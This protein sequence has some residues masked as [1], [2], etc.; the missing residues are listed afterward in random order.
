MEIID[1]LNQTNAARQQILKIVELF[2]GAPADYPNPDDPPRP[3][4]PW[5]PIIR[6]A[7]GETFV[8]KP[9]PQPWTDPFSLY[10]RSW[11]KYVQP[12]P[13]P[14]SE[15]FEDADLLETIAR[16]HPQ[17][18]DLIGDHRSFIEA[19]L[20][21]QPLPPRWRLPEAV[22]KSL[23]RRADAARDALAGLRRGGDLAERGIIIVG[24]REFRHLIE[25]LCGNDF[26]FWRPKPR[27]RGWKNSFDALDY[28]AMAAQFARAA[29]ESAYDDLQESYREATDLLIDAA[30][31]RLN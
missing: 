14:W 28:L 23:I 3:P 18:W 30:L 5:D 9:G 8:I 27:P 29:N 16:R 1:T 15:F 24:G 13:D 4:G 26:R 22:A 17:V 11:K 2:S 7:F 20:N 31:A 10:S 25:E 12:V 19:M 21:P 6:E